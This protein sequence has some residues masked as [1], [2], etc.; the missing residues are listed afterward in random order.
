[1][2]HDDFD[3]QIQAEETREYSDYVAAEEL[4]AIEAEDNDDYYSYDEDLYG[5]NRF[6]SDAYA[7]DE[8]QYDLERDEDF[9]SS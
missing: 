5:S 7:D 2:I 3:T 1:M 4:A 6:E 9:Y 8:C